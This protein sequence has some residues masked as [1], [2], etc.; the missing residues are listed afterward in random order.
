MC[1]EPEGLPWVEEGM[2]HVILHDVCAQPQELALTELR[3]RETIEV[4]SSPYLASLCTAAE[5]VEKG[6]FARTWM[7]R[8]LARRLSL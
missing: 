4:D 7:K 1:S 8:A 5:N 6:C 3:I 2:H